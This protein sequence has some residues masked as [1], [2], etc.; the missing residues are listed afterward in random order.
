MYIEQL[1]KIDINAMYQ[2]TTQERLLQNLVH[3]YEKFVDPRLVF[4][5]FSFRLADENSQLAPERQGS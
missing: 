2:I 5:C 1:G 3:E 4:S